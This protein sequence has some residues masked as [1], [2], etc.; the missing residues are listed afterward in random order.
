MDNA[1]Y[2]TLTRQ[3]GL[4]SQLRTVANNI[5]NADTTGYRGE[6][7]G[8]SEVV[9]T[10]GTGDSISMA[11]ARV[12]LTDLAQGSLRQTGGPFDLAIEGEGFFLVETPQG[13]RLT[14]AGHFGPNEA[15]DIVTPDGHRLLDA[16]GAPLFVP[17]GAGAIGIAPDGTVS[18]GGLPVGQVGLFVPRD[19]LT[20]TREGATLFRAEGGTDPAP[21]GRVLQGFLEDSNVEPVQELAR[22][23]EV[24]RAYE[25][26]QGFLEREDDR[27]RKTI[28]AIQ[29][30]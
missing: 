22:M 2:A 9:R 28:Q 8:F 23:V 6:A 11:T 14:R 21:A 5:A 26:G 27:I 25:L 30:R 20:L 3:S 7:L 10:T 19:P 24:Q 4:L 17:Q 18:A 12:H 16:G 15:G 13:P 1:T 29:T